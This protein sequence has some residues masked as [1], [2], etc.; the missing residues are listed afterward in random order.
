MKTTKFLGHDCVALENASLQLLVTQSVGPRIISLR[1]KGGENLFAELP[2]VT[3]ALPDGRLYHLY[4]GHRL[5]HAPE[6]MPRTYQPDDEP[7]QISAV[8]D[9]LVVTQQTEALT[10]MQKSLRVSLWGEEPKV[11]I[12]HTLTNR[13]VW[14]VNC[15]V[16]A[17]TQLKAGGFAILPQAR[18][19]TGFLPNRSLAIW[20]YNDMNSPQLR[21]GKD[22]IFMHAPM[23]QRFKLGFPNHRGWLAYWQAGTLFVKRATFDPQGAYCDFNSSS[24]CF[25]NEEFIELETLAPLTELRPGASVTHDE[26]WELYALDDFQAEEGAA[27]RMVERLRLD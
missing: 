13:G 1:F 6:V 16:W 20:P 14:P 19:E 24:E 12:E 3:D 2:D 25:C 8:D 10:G 5:W 27:Q 15:A 17:I 4:G 23:H 9:G 11:T 7:V 18:D 26:T 22:Y 21:W